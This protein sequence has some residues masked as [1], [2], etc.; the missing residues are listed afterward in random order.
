MMYSVLGHH[1]NMKLEPVVDLHNNR[2]IGYE[3]LSRPVDKAINV[4]AFFQ[5][6]PLA[7]AQ[8]CLARQ[9]E[10]YQK[11]SRQHP[12]L[13]EGK[14]LFVNVR[15]DLM[16]TEG[17]FAVF[18][19]FSREFDIA[20]EVDA[21]FEPLCN[22]GQ[23]NVRRMHEQNIHVW[24]DDYTG[25]ESLDLA[26]WHGVKFDKNFFWLCYEQAACHPL[27]APRASICASNNIVEG[28]E[29]EDQRHYAIKRGFHYGQGYLWQA[30]GLVL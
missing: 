16:C 27:F 8:A 13:F 11:L 1:F 4:E 26:A 2:I 29:T 5:L 22:V 24:V 15:R 28:I 3:A 10:R 9:L 21:S 30:L 17:V 19:P 18:L 12:E 14:R 25:K 7:A 20:V 6:I 23:Y